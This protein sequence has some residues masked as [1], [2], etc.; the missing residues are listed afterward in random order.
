M[1]LSQ[2][3]PATLREDPAGSLPAGFR[4]LLRAGYLRSSAGGVLWMPLG[5]RLAARVTGWLREAL[6]VQGWAQV[7][8]APSHAAEIACMDIAGLPALGGWDGPHAPPAAS[9]V[10]LAD[11]YKRLPI[12][13]Y[14]LSWRR[15][16]PEEGDLWPSTQRLVIQAWVLGDRSGV[17]AAGEELTSVVGSAL[18]RLGLEV[19]ITALPQDPGGRIEIGIRSDGSASEML[20]CRECGFFARRTST[21]VPAPPPDAAALR[22]LEQVA[23]PGA[24]TIPSLCVL[25]NLSPAQTAKAMLFAGRPPGEKEDQT[26]L[27]MV[28]GDREV[29]WHKL[30]GVS[31]WRGLRRATPEEIVAIGAV[32]GFASPV[33]LL[34]PWILIDRV[35]AN[36]RNLAT[37]ANRAGYHLL[38]TTC[39]RDYAPWRVGDLALASAGDACPHC[40]AELKL[41]PG[42]LMGVCQALSPEPGDRLG[43]YTDQHGGSA[44]LSGLSLQLDVTTAL[45][46][47]AGLQA[48]ERGLA[49]RPAVAP[50]AA[51]L[52][53]MTSCEAQALELHAR[54]AGQRIQALV[55][56]RD[57]SPGVKLKDA[58]LIGLPVRVIVSQK[59]IAAGGVEITPR[60]A[61]EKRIVQLEEVG[62]EVLRL[63]S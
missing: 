35:V 23:T 6:Q 55:D 4:R 47:L 24:D 25:L 61:G 19:V 42:H 15:L 44:P 53:A 46:A 9:L 7:L 34:H 59:S 29:S 38:N 18:H 52:I 3:L 60:G 39:G 31:G 17:Q 8:S 36:S 10:T 62:P 33:G 63:I 40:G 22:P 1:R 16:A 50:F 21:P 57:A 28:R 12:K 43:S 20:A 41:E 5:L 58:D 37:G 27:V 45:G 48:D 26:L 2:S 32:P 13:A 51:H 30:A 54:L 11:S 56:D 14:E 49:W